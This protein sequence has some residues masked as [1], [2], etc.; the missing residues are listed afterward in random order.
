ME[1]LGGARSG[2]ERFDVTE[3]FHHVFWMG[4]MNYRLTFSDETPSNTKKN[5]AN[6]NAAAKQSVVATEDVN[7]KV[8]DPAVGAED[9]S[10]DS[11]HEDEGKEG[12]ES[13]KSGK[14]AK[15]AEQ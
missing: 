11:E 3:Q 10:S 1:I 14:A 8:A 2:D 12:E 6:L 15:K 7:V 5:I 13:H 9:E 4:D